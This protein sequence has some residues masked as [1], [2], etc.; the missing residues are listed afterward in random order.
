MDRSREKSLF[1]RRER[2]VWGRLAEERR[3][4]EGLAEELAAARVSWPTLPSLSKSWPPFGAGRRSLVS[5]LFEPKKRSVGW[6][7]FSGSSRI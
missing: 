7:P 3:S 1:L 2:Y 5:E 4:R 6:G